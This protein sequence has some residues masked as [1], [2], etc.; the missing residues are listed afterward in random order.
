MT[1][2]SM[3]VGGIYLGIALET[4][5]RFSSKW[6]N[7]TFLTYFM[8]ICFWLVQ[9]FILFY[10]LYLVNGG[11]IRVYSVIACLLGFAAYQAFIAKTYQRILERLIII[12]S[13]IYNFL[14]KLI[15]GLVITPIK[16]I[17]GF[18]VTSLLLIFKGIYTALTFILKI[19]FTP[20]L[21]ILKKL[22]KLLPTYL[23]NI[24]HKIAGFYSIIENIVNK[25]A[26]FFNRTRR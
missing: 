17:I 20:V 12:M 14:V 15:H 11:E 3:I 13:S 9:S 26:N 25:V 22:Y 24:L 7:N 21:W 4:F 8:E 23:Q 19:I 5:R 16:V 10:I 6:K 2:I 1:M 18:L